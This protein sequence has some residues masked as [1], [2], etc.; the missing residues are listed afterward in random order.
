MGVNIHY[1]CRVGVDVTLESIQQQHDAVLMAVGLGQGRQT[2]IPKSDHGKVYRAVDLLHKITVNEPFEL[3]HCAVVIGGGN[4]AM[5]IARSLA[6]LQKQSYGHVDVVVTALEERERFMADADEIKEAL[7]EGI[8]IRD[9]CGPQ[10]CEV[11]ASGKLVGLKTWKV[12][13][14]FDENNRFSPQYDRES[15]TI[16]ACDTVIEA[17]GQYADVSFIDETLTEALEWQ[18]GRLQID[19]D[20]RTNVEW[21]W[22][23]GDCV[24]GP[25]VVHAVADG[26]RV[27][28][29]IHHYLESTK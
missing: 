14:I 17:I 6:R 1:N 11:D 7:E 13:S 25:D 15:E 21:L 23:A 19:A 9:K 20:G 26:H 16:H 22:A 18:R 2:R 3:P 27:A 28:K 10:Q 4:V 8:I 5:D 29:S 12:I 24:N